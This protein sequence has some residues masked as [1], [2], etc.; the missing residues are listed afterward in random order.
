MTSEEVETTEKNK[1]VP[2]S[3]ST[4]SSLPDEITENILARVSRWNYS[5]LS[6]VSKR[7]HSLVSSKD[8]YKTRSQIGADETC[9]YFLLKLHDHPCVSW[10]SLRFKPDSSGY[11]I[12]PI[13]S[14]CTDSFPELSYIVT[15]D[16]DI[17][18]IGG[19]HK[20]PSSSVRIFDCRSHTWRDGHNMTVARENAQT[21]ILDEKIYV[22][23]GCDI[24]EYN[25][26]W[27]EVFDI[28]SQSWSALPGPGADEDELR[29][30]LRE[31]SEYYYIVNVFGGKIYVVVNEKDYTYEPKNGIWKLV[32]EKPGFIDTVRGWCEMGN[33]IYGCTD[34][35]NLMWSASEFEGREWREIKGL[36]KLREHPT[37]GHKIGY[38]FELVDCGGQLL[39]MWDPYP[40]EPMERSNK[41]W[42]AKISLESRCNGREVWGNV[43]CVDVLTFPVESYERFCCVDATV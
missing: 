38:E 5:S 24:D 20:E 36:E 6:L 12:V 22:I 1:T 28:K 18:I 23:G 43:E 16:S 10:F 37:G 17:Y 15:V 26:N 39:V 25:A 30:H 40:L 2:E 13:P 42:Y 9:L 14:S 7:F 19:S 29:N 27:I 34:S 21:V 32:R 33:L 35:G 3:P 31:Y 8:I 4:F 11:L 41:I